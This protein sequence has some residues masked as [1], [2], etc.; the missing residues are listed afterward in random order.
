MMIYELLICR[1]EMREVTSYIDRVIEMC[2][3]LC[4]VLTFAV[5]VNVFFTREYLIG[6]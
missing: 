3:Y 4:R 5:C 1:G 2:G 6:W